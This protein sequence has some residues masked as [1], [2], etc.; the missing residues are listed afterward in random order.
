VA[1]QFDPDPDEVEVG[2]SQSWCLPD[3]DPSL[4]IDIELISPAGEVETVTVASRDE[5][6]SA[7]AAKGYDPWSEN[8]ASWLAFPTI[9]FGTYRVVASQGTV[10]AETTV[11][12]VNA[13][14]AVMRIRPDS[15][16]PGT[17]FTVGLAGF[18]PDSDVP[19]NLYR[20]AIGDNFYTYATTLFVAADDSGRAVGVLETVP[21]DPI[22]QYAFFGS[23][24][25][26]EFGFEDATFELTAP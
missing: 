7:S 22:A 25:S 1:L 20:A 18:E 19:L 2:S 14:E 12:V 15:G 8:F 17:A 24:T 11:E 26:Y 9:D 21:S 6:N 13:S 23:T 3:F 5:T 10:I 4:P 16:P